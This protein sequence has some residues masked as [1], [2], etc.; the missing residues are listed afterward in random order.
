MVFASVPGEP[1]SSAFIDWC[2]GLGKHVV[3]PDATPTAPTP[4]D[5]RSFD[6]VVVPGLA[7]TTEGDRLGQ[8]GGWYDRFLSQVRDDCATIGVTFSAQVVNEL[9]LDS[10]DVRLDLII[11]EHGRFATTRSG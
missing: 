11:G 7:F 5:P 10:H 1:D 3:V 8:G 2:V 4:A 6:V 9:P